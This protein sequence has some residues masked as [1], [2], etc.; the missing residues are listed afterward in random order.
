MSDARKMSFAEIQK[1]IMDMDAERAELEAA[2][3]AKRGEE[4]KVL[5]DAYAKKL[6]AGGFSISEGIKALAPYDTAAA[7]RSGV[8]PRPPREVE[9]GTTYRNPETGETWTAGG[10]G[11]VV[12]WLQAQINAGKSAASFSTNASSLG[13]RNGEGASA[14]GTT[15]RAGGDQVGNG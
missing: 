7:K 13:A 6:Q 12:G 10:K 4:I 8:A 3:Q 15:E 11:R 14:T 9:T 1:R 5:A 2:L